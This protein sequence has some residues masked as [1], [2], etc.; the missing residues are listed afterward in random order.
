MG[1]GGANV[2]INDPVLPAGQKIRINAPLQYHGVTNDQKRSNIHVYVNGV[3]R[4]SE[5]VQF[6]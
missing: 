5:L 2:V 6:L 4:T 3:D 1:Q